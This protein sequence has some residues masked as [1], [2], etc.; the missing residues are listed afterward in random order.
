MPLT[1]TDPASGKEGVSTYDHVIA[2]TPLGRILLEWKSWKKYDAPCGQMPW[3]EMV[4]GHDLP[5]AKAAAQT[6]WDKKAT[7][8]NTLCTT[9]S[10]IE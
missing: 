2:E 4:H 10:P 1:W 7:E 5:S 6:A 9:Y 8:I 3:D